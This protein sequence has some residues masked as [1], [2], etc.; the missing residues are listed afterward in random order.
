MWQYPFVAEKSDEWWPPA[1]YPAY[2]VKPALRRED[3]L[4]QA[5]HVTRSGWEKTVP[6]AWRGFW[7]RGAHR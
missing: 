3:T 7:I 2:V 5:L 6:H 1:Q 4:Q